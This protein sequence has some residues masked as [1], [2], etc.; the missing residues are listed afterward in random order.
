MTDTQSFLREIEISSHAGHP[1]V[2]MFLGACLEVDMNFFP[3]NVFIVQEYLPNGSLDD[4]VLNL[5]VPLKF[6]R[7]LKWAKHI[8]LGMQWLHGRIVHRDLKPSNI[9]IDEHDNA[10]ICDFGLSDLKKDNEYLIDSFKAKGS[11][12]W[13]APEVLSFQ[14]FN[15]KSDVYSYGLVLWCIINRKTPFSHHNELEKFRKCICE[16]KERPAIDENIDPNLANL[17]TSCWD[18]DPDMRPKFEEIT[19]ILNEARINATIPDVKDSDYDNISISESNEFM[20][21]DLYSAKTGNNFWRKYYINQDFALYDT[22][23]KDFCKFFELEF[24]HHDLVYLQNL[25]S[26]KK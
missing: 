11:P 8:S 21:D 9:L 18:H 26:K 23:E 24:D 3:R 19:E 7:S 15:E 16:Q 5:H 6:E 25:F 20:S 12:L 1:H 10:K 13:M 17:M 22:F 4:Y 2:A 14:K